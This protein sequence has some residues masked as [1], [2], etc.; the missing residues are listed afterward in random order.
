MSNGIE[1]QIYC[2]DIL[3]M[4]LP[5]N[6]LVGGWARSYLLDDLSKRGGT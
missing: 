3:K 2:A 1:I 5:M 6:A 4:C